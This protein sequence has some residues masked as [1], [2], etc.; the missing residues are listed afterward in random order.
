[1][2]QSQQRRFMQTSENE[3]LISLEKTTKQAL[4]SLDSTS[5]QSGRFKIILTLAVFMFMCPPQHWTTRDK[6]NTVANL[7]FVKGHVNKP[8]CYWKFME[9]DRGNQNR[10]LSY[11]GGSIMV[12]ICYVTS[13]PGWLC[14]ICDKWNAFISL[15]ICIRLKLLNLRPVPLLLK[16]CRRW[17]SLV[18]MA[19]LQHQNCFQYIQCIIGLP[20]RWTLETANSP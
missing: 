10:T 14:N 7:Q 13:W 3:L 16:L 4:K 1:M 18:K 20:H 6:K 15:L 2:S 17:D 5:L 9:E 19:P 8:E 12:W 11:G